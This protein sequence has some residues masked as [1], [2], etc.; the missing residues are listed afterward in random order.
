M[1]AINFNFKTIGI[2]NVR[3]YFFFWWPQPKF[4]RVIVCEVFLSSVID[5][6]FFAIVFWDFWIDSSAFRY[7]FLGSSSPQNPMI[8][9]LFWGPLKL[10]RPHESI[11]LCCVY[12][13][14]FFHHLSLYIFLI[15]NWKQRYS[16]FKLKICCFS[17]EMLMFI[18]DELL[19]RQFS[20]HLRL[21]LLGRDDFQFQLRAGTCSWI[22]CFNWLF[23]GKRNQ[24]W[25]FIFFMFRTFLITN[26]CFALNPCILLKLDLERIFWFQIFK[27][28]FRFKA[29]SSFLIFLLL[30]IMKPE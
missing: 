8:S 9:F 24:Q 26:F 4:K 27:P 14:S 13:F 3:N 19:Q 20:F 11:W 2:W 17:F 21:I 29:G 28:K 30:E 16:I 25:I 6:L 15:F 18:F 1:K 12:W 22:Y 5:N 7:Q 23:Q 10:D